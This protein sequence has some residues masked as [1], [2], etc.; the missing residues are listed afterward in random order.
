MNICFQFPEYMRM[1][2]VVCMS[3]KLSDF[4]NSTIGVKQGCPLSPTLFGLCIDELEEMV[5]KFVKVECV[6]EVSAAPCRSPPVG[7]RGGMPFLHLAESAPNCR[8]PQ[9][10]A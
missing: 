8:Q 10:R 1:L 2:Y 4:F 3:D 9:H 5:A 6:K 7:H